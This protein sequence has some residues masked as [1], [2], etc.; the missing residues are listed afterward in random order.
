VLKTSY[1]ICTRNR[2][3]DIKRLFET[4]KI[5]TYIPDEIL[6]IDSSDNDQTESFIN[7]I[8]DTVAS[9][10]HYHHSV[11]GLT[12][13]RNIGIS[14]ATGDIIF[15]TDDDGILDKNY[16][17]EKMK[18]YEDDSVM[19]VGARETNYVVKSRVS[20]FLRKMFLL[21]RA[22]GRGK[23][24]LSGYPAYMH[25]SNKDQIAET[26]I[27]G[28]FCSY[29]RKVFD[30]FKYDENLSGYAY[31]E[32]VD[33]SYR[34]SRKYRLLYNPH[35]QLYHNMSTTERINQRKYFFMT[36]YNHFYL[37][38]KN[39]GIGATNI[40][41]IIWAYIGIF[42]RA[43]MTSLYYHEIKPLQG[44]FEGLAMIVKNPMGY[45]KPI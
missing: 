13:Q 44:F 29:R 31:M 41:P 23:M 33:F 16:F 22:D 25:M 45:K 42:I 20:S 34:V 8:R 15:F 9:K 43:V 12:L 38:K 36:I 17:A 2:I 4:I 21:S 30:D 5:Q 10:I 18:C 27:L 14:K 35:S 32:D 28:G 1:I 39:I 19:G 24:Q 3:E 11:P 37:T 7:E 40:L 26:E 6:I